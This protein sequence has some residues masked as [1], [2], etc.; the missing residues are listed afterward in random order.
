MATS[1]LVEKSLPDCQVK[2][3][4]DVQGHDLVPAVFREIL[5]F[6]APAQLRS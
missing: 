2:D 3:C 4:L 6:G 1:L 5:S